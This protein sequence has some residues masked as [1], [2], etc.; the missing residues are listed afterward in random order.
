MAHLAAK[1]KIG[2][3]IG[4]WG[5]ATTRPVPAPR[6]PRRRL[7]LPGKA[8]TIRAVEVAE[9]SKLAI[10]A[11][12]QGVVRAR[13]RIVVALALACLAVPANPAWARTV[14]VVALGDSNTYGF[15]TKR[16]STYPAQLEGMLQVLGYDVTI[17]NA[18]VNGDTTRG[19]LARL[20]R[21]VP[22]GTD[23]VIVFLGRNDW[24]KNT[25]ESAISYNLA[26]IVGRL[27]Q[28]GIQVLLVG[29][30]P[31]DFS[32]VAQK[33]G[34]LYYPDFFDGVMVLNRKLRKYRNRGD[35]DGH[36]NADGYAVVAT[37]LLPSAEALIARV[38][39]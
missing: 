8:A 27:R 9:D 14:H 20:D 18:G 6:R 13:L 4:P 12:S 30:K 36:L 15:G 28:R 29:F 32:A 39:K 25:P 17:A 24:R 23:A 7:D 2:V 37:R 5:R 11:V 33:Y 21:A 38:A 34:A 3:G 19:A 26:L 22:A 1:V 31:N 10:A 35:I 16:Q